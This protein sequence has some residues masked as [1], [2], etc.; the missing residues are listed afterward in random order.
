M[1]AGGLEGLVKFTYYDPEGIA[2][3]SFEARCDF[4]P[5]V[6]D[7]VLPESGRAG[8]VIVKAVLHRFIKVGDE[9]QQVSHVILMD[10]PNSSDPVP[11]PP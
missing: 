4:L 6:G 3:R 10:P 8:Q 11:E 2:T 1:R 9:F 7:R 5:R